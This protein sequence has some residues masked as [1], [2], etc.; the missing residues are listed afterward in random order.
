[1]SVKLGNNGRIVFSTFLAP[2]SSYPKGSEEWHAAFSRSVQSEFDRMQFAHPK[3]FAT[4]LVKA[5]NTDYRP[6][7]FWPEEAKGSPDKYFRLVIG[8]SW[9]EARQMVIGQGGKEGRQWC[10]VIDRALADWEAKNRRVGN[11]TGANQYTKRGIA[12]DTH[13]SSESQ[14]RQSAPGIRRR[15]IKRATAGDDQ[16][17]ALVHQLESG[18]LSV[19][20]AAITAGMR[21]KYIRISPSP[22]KAAKS[23]ASK[24][25]RD[26]CLQLLE[27]LS[28]LCL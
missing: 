18:E 2:Y 1:M 26:W 22:S 5:V 3:G 10:N 17:A 15:L 24:Q 8:C 19:N 11:P 6:W 4:L 12:C 16:A 25:G 27:E 23:L 13:N 21:E 14:D 9:A 7:E 28:E 20:Q